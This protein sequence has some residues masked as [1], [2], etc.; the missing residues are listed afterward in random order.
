M[1][2]SFNLLILRISQIPVL[3]E[4]NISKEALEGMIKHKFGA[5][6]LY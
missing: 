4:K 3:G 5:M 6:F 1:F 2:N